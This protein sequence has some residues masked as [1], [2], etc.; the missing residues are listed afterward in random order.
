[1]SDD[2]PQLQMIWPQRLLDAPPE[3]R[4]PTGYVLRT[5]RRGDEP[6]W[7]EIMRLS[8]WPGWSDEKLRPWIA[9]VPPECWFFAIDERNDQIVASAMGLHDHSDQHPFGGEL[10]WVAS[11]PA[12][13]G[14]G[15]GAAVC[16]A[17]TRRLL[18]MGYKDI[19]LYS[20]DFR[21]PALKTYLKMGYVP[22][23]YLPEMAERWQ[24]ICDQLN[25]PYTPDSWRLEAAK[26]R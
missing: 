13:V 8:G 15:L 18:A 6:R 3:I 5:Y 7:Y 14:K 20:E 23:L 11:D 9:R 22:L 2:L 16:A 24:A 26:S 21:L 1:M 4:L 25:W 12:H 17:V 10:G 19:H